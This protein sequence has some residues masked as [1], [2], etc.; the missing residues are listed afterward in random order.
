MALPWLKSESNDNAPVQGTLCV[1]LGEQTVSTA[2]TYLT[3]TETRVGTISLQRKFNTEEEFIASLDECLRDLGDESEAYN[4]AVFCLSEHWADAH[5]VLP[6]KVTWIERAL[7]ELSLQA[8]G[9][10]GLVDAF[11]S[12]L[13][14]EPTK[15]TQLVFFVFPHTITL[16]VVVNQHVVTTA[17][18]GRSAE[19]EADCTELLARIRSRLSE[20]DLTTLAVTLASPDLSDSQLDI[21]QQNLL[22]YSWQTALPVQSVPQV[23]TVKREELYRHLFHHTAEVLRSKRLGA[24]WQ[25]DPVAA[26][27]ES[28][29]GQEVAESFAQSAPVGQESNLVVPG[30]HE[31][32]TETESDPNPATQTT[33]APSRRKKRGGIGRLFRGGAGSAKRKYILIGLILGILTLV[34]VFVAYLLLFSVVEIAL[35]PKHQTI[36]KD[37][38]VVLEPGSLQITDNYSLP[39]DSVSKEVTVTAS[40]VTTGKKTIGEKATGKVKII[41]KTDQQKTFE[42]GT[43][44]TSGT[45]VVFELNDSVTVPAAS[46]SATAT[47]EVKEYGSQEAAVTASQI[48]DTGN[49]GSNQDLKVASYADSSY[50]AQ[51]LESFTGGSSED[52]AVVADKDIATLRADLKKQAAEEGQKALEE[53]KAEGS[54]VAP[55]HEVT[56]VNEELSAKAGEEAEDLTIK[57]T[58]KATAFAYNSQDTRA[59][60]QAVLEQAIPEGTQLAQSEPQVLTQ[61]AE[62]STSAQTQLELNVSAQVVSQIDV[63]AVTEQLRGR[64]VLSVSQS[65]VDLPGVQSTVIRWLPAVAS[66]FNPNIPDKTGRIRIYVSEE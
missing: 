56:I 26:A 28:V 62:A 39:I 33:T 20:A 7:Q 61:F 29:F 3:P 65:A 16:N 42:S 13:L 63:A 30:K 14:K 12:M 55:P 11:I 52:V 45:G 41:N 58:A 47:G 59:L 18:A 37:I 35:Q 1:L 22:E 48:G 10:I 4:E 6:E 36:T 57:L 31:P 34:V 8:L 66:W 53:G 23:S 38:S 19:I 24:H 50:V 32:V 21:L 64:P 17:S 54:R 46:T 2:L 15:R 43:T 44:L 51:S 60:A 5:D 40:K 27:S 9:Y 25:A 49:I